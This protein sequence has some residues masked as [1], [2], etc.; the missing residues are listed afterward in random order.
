MRLDAGVKKN[1]ACTLEKILQHNALAFAILMPYIFLFGYLN[2]VHSEIYFIL[3]SNTAPWNTYL[4]FVE[5]EVDVLKPFLGV[6]Y[7][8][9]TTAQAMLFS[10]TYWG[11][12]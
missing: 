6:A 1:N 2:I 10:N 7:L 3:E 11:W 5:D 8:R 9:D 12:C 4:P